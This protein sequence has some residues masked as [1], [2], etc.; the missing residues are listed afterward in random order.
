M[1]I[2]NFILSIHSLIEI[3]KTNGISF[4]QRLYDCYIFITLTVNVVALIFR[5]NNQF[6][7]PTK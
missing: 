1:T 5:L 2:K 3:D 7:S 4:Q 6:S